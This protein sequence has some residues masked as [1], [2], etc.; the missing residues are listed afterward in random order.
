[1]KKQFTHID[2]TIKNKQK[3]NEIY[4]FISIDKD[5]FMNEGIMAAGHVAD[6]L[7]PMITGSV[8][9]LEWMKDSMRQARNELNRDIKLVKFTS[10][11][12]IDF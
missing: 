4:V 5:E 11:E 12:I 10:R 7:S 2:P 3:I 6:Q 8:E 9:N 1:M